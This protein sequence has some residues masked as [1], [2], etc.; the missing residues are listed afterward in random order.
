ML[1]CWRL[2]AVEHCVEQSPVPIEGAGLYAFQPAAKR[3]PHAHIG[4]LKILNIGTVFHPER[5]VFFYF[6]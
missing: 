3:E 5:R 4:Q 1:I 2:F 6:Q